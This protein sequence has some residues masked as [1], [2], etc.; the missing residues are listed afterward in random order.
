MATAHMTRGFDGRVLWY[1]DGDVRDRSLDDLMS[2]QQEVRPIEKT[3]KIY[4]GVNLGSLER[5]KNSGKRLLCHFLH[6]LCGIPLHQKYA[7]AMGTRGSVT[8]KAMG[9]KIRSEG[10]GDIWLGGTHYRNLNAAA[11]K[12][13]R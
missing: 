5:S 1:L 8:V 12:L 6:K 11:R 3:R 9:T 10:T 13:S 4:K 2:E 7:V